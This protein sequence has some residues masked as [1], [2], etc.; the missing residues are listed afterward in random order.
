MGSCASSCRNRN[1]DEN[2][3]NG[4]KTPEKHEDSMKN[5]NTYESKSSLPRGGILT[6][7]KEE[8]QKIQKNIQE[9][10]NLEKKEGGEKKNA[11]FEKKIEIIDTDMPEKK[12][13]DKKN[14]WNKLTDKLTEKFIS[15]PKEQMEKDNIIKEDI[16]LKDSKEKNEID[17]NHIDT[18]EDI[19]EKVEEE[20]EK[21]IE[22]EKVEDKKKN[23]I[24]KVKE[25]KKIEIDI[26]EE[27]K[28]EEIN[29]TIEI[30]NEK[31]EKNETE[32][33]AKSDEEEISKHDS[34]IKV[35]NKNIE[36]KKI[37]KEEIKKKL[38]ELYN[39][40]PESISPDELVNKLSDFIIKL[41]DTT[42]ESDK[43]D[44]I[45]FTK[46]LCSFYENNKDK[47][48]NKLNDY[49][50]QISDYKTLSSNKS[51]RAIRSCIQ[52][53]K[54]KMKERLNQE[55]IPS[56]KIITYE[57]FTQIVKETELSLK[58]SYMDILLF[59]M[60]DKVPKGKSFHLFNAIVIVDFLK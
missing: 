54:D 38:D 9:T 8:E 10:S 60:K 13:K 40:F 42:L 18:K 7:E 14:N 47:I 31:E 57:F 48:Y 29:D 35:I 15:N 50:N 36:T 28:K 17:E 24:K 37:S 51:N 52:K 26:K 19:V 41:I 59:Q 32:V 53:C 33:E 4:K 56:D 55:D 49:I 5:N 45:D 1:P 3:E 34:L 11:K 2:E 16:E 58:K 46:K 25:E 27:E 6:S 22:I 43:K 21:K 44:L 12:E 23:E 30:K 39:S 20:E